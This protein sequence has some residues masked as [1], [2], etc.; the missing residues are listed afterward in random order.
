M[1]IEDLSIEASIRVK[2]NTDKNAVKCLEQFN[3]DYP[4]FKT[5]KRWDREF[6]V[7]LKENSSDFI[8]VKSGEVFSSV[9]D[10]EGFKYIEVSIEEEFYLSKDE[11]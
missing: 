9:E 11:E 10:F 2:F 8:K 6:S 5:K 3:E 1:K 7:F 4:E